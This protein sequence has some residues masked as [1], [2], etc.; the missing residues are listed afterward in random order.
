[1]VDPAVPALAV[2]HDGDAAGADARSGRRFLTVRAA[3]VEDDTVS[4][5]E[6][7][8]A[9]VEL[10][11]AWLSTLFDALP[12]T[13]TTGMAQVAVG[14]Y[15]RR[16][17]LPHSDLDVLLLHGGGGD[18]AAVADGVF[19]PV[20]DSGIALDHAVRTVAE[21]RAVAAEDVAA[22][23]GLV[24]A[25]HVAGDPKITETLRAGVLAD[26]RR[27][28][29]A[30]LPKLAQAGRDRLAE[31]GELAHLLEPDLKQAYGG[32]REIVALRA[33]AASWVADRPH[34]AA[35]SEAHEWLLVVRDALHRCTGRR[36]DRLVFEDQDAVALALGL[37]DADALMRRVAEAGR[38]IAYAADV[39]WRHVERTLRG[40]SGSAR[41]GR[42]VSRRLL[43]PGIVEHDGEAVLARDAQPHLDPVLPLRAAAGAAQAGLVLAPATVERLALQ[44]PPLPAVWPD[45]ARDALVSLLGSGRAAIPVWD[46]LEAVG[47]VVAWLPEWEPVRYRPQRT[48]VHRHTVD[49][50]QVETAALAAGLTRRVSRPD[51]LLLA[52]LFH[53]LG[54]GG[55]GDHS[56]TGAAIVTGMG[57][58]M[59][60]SLVD[61]E[62]LGLLVRHHLLLP[63][64]ATRRDLDD[65]N[66]I[67]A[68]ARAVG[69]AD[70]LDLL[71]ALTEADATAA[72]PLAWSPMRAQLIGDLVRRVRLVLGGQRF[73]KPPVLEPWQQELAKSTALA[74]RVDLSGEPD[75][76]CRVTV[77]VPGRP[78]ALAPVAGVLALHRLD[79]RHATIQTADGRAVQVWHATTGFRGPPEVDLL[80]TDVVAALDGRID[81]AGKLRARAAG[82]RRRRIAGYADPHVEVLPGASA[83]TTVIEVRA[84]D[85]PGLLYRL[86]AA[87]ADCQAHVRSA[88]VGTLGA[89]AVDVF[90][91]VDA[92]GQQ[93]SED[94]VRDVMS[95]VSAALHVLC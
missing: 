17:L 53:D 86:V 83:D 84:H 13:W 66:T 79:V 33:V 81:V 28:A 54:K 9:L 80:R 3:I 14:G 29:A 95:A 68:V 40:R 36:Q 46:S 4:A 94:A 27:Q 77:V 61:A 10:S 42:P 24:D 88:V 87:I 91:L 65:P 82:E 57:R 60:L 8:S 2:L 45:A 47:L 15:G 52:A 22:A 51:L 6:R 72:G 32:L 21:A 67:D 25:R 1:V 44:C 41:A 18:V 73:R 93:L 39:T 38:A 85:A 37:F 75:D 58:R 89:E 56:E 11:D 16:E 35:V 20:W 30:R 43:A 49:R 50:H 76:S 31:V 74:V 7:R 64:M 5:A 62:R 19:Y 34:A 90:Y 92:D 55:P 78:D 23:V 12:P 70:V 71:A 63:A 26:W 48:P 59:G 69:S